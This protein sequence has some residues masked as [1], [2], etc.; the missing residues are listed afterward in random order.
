MLLSKHY[1]LPLLCGLTC[2][3]KPATFYRH[4]NIEDESLLWVALLSLFESFQ[5]S[6]TRS[7]CFPFNEAHSFDNEKRMRDLS[8]NKTKIEI[9]KQESQTKQNL[10]NNY[11]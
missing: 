1:F 6:A 5:R 4:E 9:Q 11:F 3:E 2:E 8:I 7:A 10:R